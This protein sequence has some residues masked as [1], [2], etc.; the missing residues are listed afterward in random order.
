MSKNNVEEEPD[1]KICR[2]EQHF[3]PG[4]TMS[5]SQIITV[6]LY[7]EMIL[8][9]TV[10]HLFQIMPRRLFLHFK[11]RWRGIFVILLNG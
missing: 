9:R 7:I 2:R 11:M 8:N 5:L 6:V 4:N 3:G 1:A 10:R